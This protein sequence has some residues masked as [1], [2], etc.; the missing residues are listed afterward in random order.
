MPSFDIPIHAD[1]AVELWPGET[2]TFYIDVTVQIP[3]NAMGHIAVNLA[4]LPDI[5]SQIS[6]QHFPPG[7][8][9]LIHITVANISKNALIKIKAGDLLGWFTTVALRPM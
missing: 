7:Y 9:G 8:T 1:R 5:V 3:D 4:V 2:H 6:T